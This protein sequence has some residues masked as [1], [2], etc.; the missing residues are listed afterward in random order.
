MQQQ[1]M[2]NPVALAVFG[3]L[4]LWHQRLHIVNRPKIVLVGYKCVTF[5]LL[6]FYISALL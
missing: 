3:S 2:S 4:R 6:L 1:E 5:V